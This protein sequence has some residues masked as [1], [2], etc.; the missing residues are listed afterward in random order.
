M[1]E[2]F[3]HVEGGADNISLIDNDILPAR[4]HSWIRIRQLY[5]CL[6]S[7]E[8]VRFKAGS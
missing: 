4:L 7:S 5:R 6:N 2:R 1:D 8:R 3:G